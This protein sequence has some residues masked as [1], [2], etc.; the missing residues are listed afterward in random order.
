MLTVFSGGQG[1]EHEV[2]KVKSGTRYTV[3]SFWDNAGIVYTEEQK[4]KRAEELAKIRQD[5]EEDYKVWAENKKM[6]LTME[7]VGKNGE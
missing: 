4:K 6:G 1:H 7:Y 5:Q 2:T 3:G